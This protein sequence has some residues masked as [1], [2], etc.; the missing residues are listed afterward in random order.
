MD[1]ISRLFANLV[2]SLS[3]DPSWKLEIQFL[4]QHRP[5]FSQLRHQRHINI[6]FVTGNLS[7]LRTFS[8]RCEMKMNC[9]GKVLG[10]SVCSGLGRLLQNANKIPL[11]PIQLNLFAH[12]YRRVFTLPA[13]RELFRCSIHVSGNPLTFHCRSRTVKR[14]K[15]EQ[16]KAHLVSSLGLGL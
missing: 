13:K 4:A 5:K 6:H 10:V 16:Q 2:S 11:I 15:A 14:Q 12:F 3:M 8:P 7:S 9:A 1:H